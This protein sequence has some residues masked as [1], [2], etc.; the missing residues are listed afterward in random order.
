LSL[1]GHLY[2]EGES[3][4][5]LCFRESIGLASH[6]NWPIE[7]IELKPPRNSIIEGWYLN[8]YLRCMGTDDARNV[9]IFDLNGAFYGGMFSQPGY[10]LHL[11]DPPSLLP[12]DISK[13]A[14]STS[15]AGYF[16]MQGLRSELVHRLILRGVKQANQVV[17]MTKVI[18]DE[19]KFRY[20][21]DAKIVRPGVE[22]GV[23][24]RPKYDLDD[25][26]FHF[27]S[28]SRLEENKRIDWIIDALYSLEC[29]T[30]PL[31]LKINWKLNIVGR[32]SLA[33]ALKQRVESC[34]LSDRVIFHGHVSDAEL[35]QLWI[36]TNLF[37]MP[38]VQGYGLPALEALSRG[39]A[40]VLHKDSGV[41][42]ILGDSPW[43]TM[44]ADGENRLEKQIEAMVIRLVNGELARYEIPYLPTDAGWSEQINEIWRS[45][46]V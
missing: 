4:A 14:P 39:V 6:A 28:V 5:I 13:Y 17:A 40:V 22:Q 20:G 3:V 19:I 23:K 38:A 25:Q 34:G 2:L 16:S 42:E 1:A 21:V 7:I 37:L 18:S 36:E 43:I 27:L 29:A 45:N 44:V 33:Q 11:T 41:S 31:S 12:T 30:N 15:A 24:H 32:G 8:R 46:Y 35:E 26:E 9:L 10:T